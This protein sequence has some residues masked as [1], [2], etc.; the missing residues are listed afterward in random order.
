[1]LELGGVQLKAALHY[2]QP[3]KKPSSKLPS[4]VKRREF[5]KV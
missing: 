3:N 2:D 1:M 4:L 5:I